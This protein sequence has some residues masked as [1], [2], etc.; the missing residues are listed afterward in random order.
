MFS[1]R[2]CGVRFEIL[3]AAHARNMAILRYIDCRAGIITR[4]YL[5]TLDGYVSAMCKKAV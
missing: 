1:N 5:I 4:I 3:P 2:K